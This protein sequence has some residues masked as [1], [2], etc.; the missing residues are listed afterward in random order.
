M[1]RAG[2]RGQADGRARA[3]PIGVGGPGPPGPPAPPPPADG[4]GRPRG[5]LRRRAPPRVPELR[6]ALQR[7]GPASPPL[8]RPGVPVLR[9]G[10][11]PPGRGAGA[12]AAPGRIARSDRRPPNAALGPPMSGLRGQGTEARRREQRGKAEDEGVGPGAVVVPRHPRGPRERARDE[13]PHAGRPGSGVHQH[14]RGEPSRPRRLVPRAGL[15]RRGPT[16]TSLIVRP[17]I[18]YRPQKYSGPNARTLIVLALE[19][20]AEGLALPGERRSHGP[21][22]KGGSRCVA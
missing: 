13:V 14:P 19:V 22:G 3:A 6:R 21:L 1:H 8:P 5:R 12:P 18:R 10:A 7:R 4:T 16:T 2:R 15:P 20:R 17:H 9:R 11:R